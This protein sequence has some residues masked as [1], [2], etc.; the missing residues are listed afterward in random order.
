MPIVAVTVADW[1]VNMKNGISENT[2]R[3]ALCSFIS[4]LSLAMMMLTAVIPVGTYALP[5]FAGVLFTVIVIEYGLKW[6][7]CVYCAVSLLSLFLSGDKEAVVYFIM[8][9]GYYPTIKSILESKLKNTVFQYIIKFAIFNISV[10]IAFLIGCYI[11]GIPS[12]EFTI[13]G[14]YMPWLL[15][16]IG[17][18]FFLIYDFAIS[19][20]IT[21]YF[22]V[23]RNKIFKSKH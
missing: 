2:M 12:E 10:V 8:L 18:I 11:L 5:C 7:L 9:F 3:M 13:A 17:N 16:I 6:A 22:M 19:T 4:A 15:L 23:I 14:I 20:L 21:R 1:V